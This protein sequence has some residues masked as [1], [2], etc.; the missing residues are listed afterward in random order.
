MVH[1]ITEQMNPSSPLIPLNLQKVFFIIIHHADAKTCTWQDINA[2]HKQN[3]WNCGGYN[4][5]ITKDGEVY[6]MR[7]DNIGAQCLNM[8][9]KSYGICCE[10]DYDTET[11]MPT[12]QF[13]ALVE[14]IK[15]HKSGMPN[16]VEVV[17]HSKLFNT[18]C[19]GKYFPMDRAICEVNSN[20]SDLNNAIDFIAQHANI[21][22]E[23]W[24]KQASQVKY[25]DKFIIKIAD[26]WKGGDK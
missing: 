2:W 15:Y 11:D 10:G 19:P 13:N 8:N 6:I 7:G 18:S 26:S 16:K 3:T 24:L 25:L 5:F 23:Y 14:R 9:S 20:K 17:P 4:E 1:N 22:K 21:D 12:A